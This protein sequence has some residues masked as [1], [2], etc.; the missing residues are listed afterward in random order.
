[1]PSALRQWITA[2][3]LSPLNNNHGIFIG[4]NFIEIDGVSCRCAFIEA[5]EI[6]VIKKQPPTVR[7]DQSERWTGYLCFI[8]AKR[9]CNPFYQHCLTRTEAPVQKNNL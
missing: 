8:N 1:M 4:Q 2:E 5:I 7:I 6:D 3:P 9:M